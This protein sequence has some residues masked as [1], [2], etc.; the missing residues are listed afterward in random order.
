VPPRKS[1]KSDF[2]QVPIEQVDF[3][4]ISSVADV[5]DAFK[6]SSFQA[7]QLGMAAQ[8]WQNALEDKDRPTI[9]MGLAGSLMAGGLRKVIR[10]VITNHL[11][12]VVVTV[13]SQPYQDLYA[14]RGYN[15]WRSTPEVDDLELRSHFLDRLYDTV[16]DEE[17]FRETDDAL[18]QL[19]AKLEPRG[20][21]SRELYQFLGE[22]FD[23]PD[24]WVVAAAREQVPLFCPAVN[25][26]S[27]G[28]GMVQNY[29]RNKKAGKPFPTIDPIRDAY[30]LAQI[31]MRSKK[32]MVIYIAGGV[33]KNYIQQTEVISEVLGVEAGG[34]QY[35]V[36]LT[37]DSD[38]WGGLSGCTFKEAQSWGKIAAD[39]KMA[40][41]HVDVTIGMP[42]LV[43][44]IL[45]KQ[46]SW[47]DRKALRFDYQ[48]SELRRIEQVA[49]GAPARAGGR[50]KR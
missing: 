20:Y 40:Q 42:L 47:K 14:A 15:F 46:A 6:G 25:D 4:R 22:Q 36:Q 49:R 23:D 12:D 48:D 39:A 3:S 7:R 50:K 8:V 45:Q 38:Y 28:I 5:V 29:V 34:H 16:V 11:V 10:D 13:G 17:K 35:A 21:T 27:L 1:R 32:T 2:M 41:C 9:V 43:G 24:S 31:K 18:G 26:S 30:E 19:F 44:A 33:S 37:T